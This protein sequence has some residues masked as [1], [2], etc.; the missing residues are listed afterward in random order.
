MDRLVAEETPM[1]LIV[2]VETRLVGKT[3]A[4]HADGVARAECYGKCRR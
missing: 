2:W 1:E 4:V 3:L